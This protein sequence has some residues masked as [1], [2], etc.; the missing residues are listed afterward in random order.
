MESECVCVCGAEKR[1]RKTQDDK[2]I[3][4]SKQLS[5]CRKVAPCMGENGGHGTSCINVKARKLSY[6]RK[7]SRT[8]PLWRCPSSRY[9]FLGSSPCGARGGAVP[10]VRS[11]PSQPVRAQHK[12]RG[13]ARPGGPWAI[14]TGVSDS[15][16]I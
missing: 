7:Y 15:G 5:I 14:L 4:E 1:K 2:R 3:K 13:K 16:C 9:L 8:L 12:E 10:R 11:Q 6:S